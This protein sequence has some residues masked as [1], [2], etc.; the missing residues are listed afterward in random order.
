MGGLT[1]PTGFRSVESRVLSILTSSVRGTGLKLV[2][3]RLALSQLARSPRFGRVADMPMIWTAD[4]ATY[5]ILVR[6]NSSKYP[7]DW[8]P[9]MCKL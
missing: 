8:S 6:S 1:A 9:S 7:L 5:K 4:P 3:Y 2:V